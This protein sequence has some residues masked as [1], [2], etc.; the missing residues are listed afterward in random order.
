MFAKEPLAGRVHDQGPFLHTAR[1]LETNKTE[2]KEYVTSQL[3]FVSCS[4]G[5][6]PQLSYWAFIVTAI[7]LSFP[8]PSL[9]SPL[10]RLPSPLCLLSSL[11]L[12]LSGVMSTLQLLDA[13]DQSRGHPQTC[14]SALVCSPILQQEHPILLVSWYVCVSV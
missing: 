5:Q 12:S 1:S 7:S 14:Q 4:R 3:W 13:R 9:P 6:S 2:V 11:F 10:M 8:G